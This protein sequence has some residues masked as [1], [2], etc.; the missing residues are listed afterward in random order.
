MKRFEVQTRFTHGWL[1]VWN[2]EVIV[3][4]TYKTRAEAQADLAE[5]I[6]DM[7]ESV[8]RGEISDFDPADYRIVLVK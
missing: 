8:A 1:N 5:F 7:T 2:E 3:P 6:A 4:T